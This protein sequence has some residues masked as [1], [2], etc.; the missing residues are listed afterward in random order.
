MKQAASLTS[1]RIGAL[2]LAEAKDAA[3]R[4][5]VLFSEFVRRAVA[6]RVRVAKEPADI[7][8][9]RRLVEVADR[10]EK[11]VEQQAE[12]MNIGLGNLNKAGR[13]LRGIEERIA[14]IIAEAS[15]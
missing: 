10:L 15:K 8:D 2:G 6:E 4:E 12:A 7:V 13:G 1:F 5:G 14:H 11:A 9:V 3:D